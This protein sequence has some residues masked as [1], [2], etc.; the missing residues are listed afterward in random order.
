M[1]SFRPAHTYLT[2][3]TSDAVVL[4]LIASVPPTITAI[5]SLLSSMKNANAIKSLHMDVN[6]RI[7][8]LLEMNKK[9]SRAAG[10]L[11]QIGED[12]AAAEKINVDIKQK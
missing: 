2:M 4:A 12:K 10:K 8:Q 3:T 6:G 7:G 5:A 1:E 11:E 9:E